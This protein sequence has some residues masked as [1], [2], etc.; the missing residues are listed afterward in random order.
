MDV[1]NPFHCCAS[2]VHFR[3]E[4]N[5]GKVTYR[6]SRLTYETRPNY[7]FDCWTPKESVLRLMAARQNEDPAS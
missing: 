1:P 6:C 2:C 7:Q 5:A 3:I 4:R